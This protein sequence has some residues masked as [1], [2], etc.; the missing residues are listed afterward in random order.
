MPKLQEI[1]CFE[2]IN[3]I[4]EQ[5]PK[6][7]LPVGIQLIEMGFYWLR[8]HSG[9]DFLKDYVEAYFY[10]NYESKTLDH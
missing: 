3:E 2:A 10:Q 8:A 7:H 9:D 6:L 5:E 4:L 1:D